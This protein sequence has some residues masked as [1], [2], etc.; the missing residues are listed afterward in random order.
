M[1][2][3]SKS[4]RTGAKFPFF[5][6]LYSHFFRNFAVRKGMKYLSGGA[7]QILLEVLTSVCCYSELLQESTKFKLV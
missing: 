1:R 4:A 7:L 5:R 3:E 6:A 2:S